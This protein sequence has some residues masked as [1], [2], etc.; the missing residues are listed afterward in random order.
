V[1]WVCPSDGKQHFSPGS[2]L[3]KALEELGLAQG[4]PSPKTSRIKVVPRQ[5]QINKSGYTRQ[6]NCYYHTTK[7]GGCTWVAQEVYDKE[8]NKS[9]IRVIHNKCHGHHQQSANVKT[10]A[11]IN[12][13]SKLQQTPREFQYR[14]VAENPD[15]DFEE[16][17][18]SKET[19]KRVKHNDS[20][21]GLPEGLKLNS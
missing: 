19:F 16:L 11:L 17:K 7:R 4:Y 18:K 5:K 15:A 1:V 10:R 13:P 6:V 20:R 12:S 8:F 14:Y 21:T 9:H 3:D 2:D